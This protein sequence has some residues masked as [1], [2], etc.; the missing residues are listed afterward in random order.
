MQIALPGW[1]STQGSLLYHAVKGWSDPAESSEGAHP[2][3]PMFV[4][5]I[6][7][8][9]LR[10]GEVVQRV[11]YLPHKSEDLSLNPSVPTS[12]EGCIAIAYSP[13]VGEAEVARSLVITGHPAQRN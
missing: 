11:K 8:A 4:T 2:G 7:K 1:G 10:A 9:S 5:F 3:I 6:I 12:K 13:R